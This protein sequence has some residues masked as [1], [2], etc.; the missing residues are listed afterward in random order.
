M[1]ILSTILH[2]QTRQLFLNWST[3]MTKMELLSMFTIYEKLV[4]VTLTVAHCSSWYSP[5]FHVEGRRFRILRSVPAH[6]NTIAILVQ[7]NTQWQRVKFL[8]EYTV[9]DPEGQTEFISWR[10]KCPEGNKL[11][12]CSEGSKT[13]Y[14]WQKLTIICL[15]WCKTFNAVGASDLAIQ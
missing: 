1:R 7:I 8:K 5:Q 15:S 12:V 14:S 2:T 3:K 11:T 4:F 13:V 10:A 6:S 9:L